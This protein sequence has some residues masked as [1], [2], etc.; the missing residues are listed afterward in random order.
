MSPQSLEGGAPAGPADGVIAKAAS[1]A[2]YA[3]FLLFA[4]NLLNFFDRQ[5][6]GALGEPVRLEFHLSDTALGFLGTIFTIIYAFVGLPLGALSDRW[7]R[8]RLI[9]LGTAFW[10]VLTAATGFAQNYAQIFVARLGV[11]VGEAV[12]APAG[13][14]LIGDL[15]PP[16]QRAKAM[17]V[18]M[19]GLPAGIFLAYISAGAIATKFGWRAAF[20]FACIPGIILALM[21]LRIPE[22]VRGALD[23]GRVVTTAKD[24]AKSPFLTVLGLPTMWWI[25]MS[26]I[27]HNFNMYAINSFNTPFLQRF[28]QMSLLHASYVSSISVG[29]VGAIGLLVGGWLAD[30]MSAKRRNGRLVLSSAAMAIAAP[31]IFMAINQPKGAITTYIIFMTMG[32]ITM[33]VYYATV[34]AAIQDVIEPRLRGTAVA[35]YFCFMY[36]LGASMGPVGTGRLSDFF[37]HKAMIDAGASTMTEAFKAVGLHQAMYII[38][39]LAVAA[40][41]VLFAASRTMEKDVRKQQMAHPT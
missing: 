40:A 21:A 38:P 15:F 37:A 19:L 3:L 23:P 31:C 34:Y 36:I 24:A 8:N 39:V 6:L 11:G 16:N 20:W 25:I 12:C 9:A 5:L 41:L 32:T 28:H 35:L 26:G 2:K 1:G 10:S 33:F 22:P 18:F 27:F 7:Y 14:S 13:Q 29:A 4:I 17:G 30:K